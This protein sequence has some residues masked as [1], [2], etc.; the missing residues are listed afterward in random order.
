MQSYDTEFV[1]NT[2][3]NSTSAVCES[4]SW[5]ETFLSASPCGWPCVIFEKSHRRTRPPPPQR[6]VTARQG[7][8]IQPAAVGRR[9][10]F[11]GGPDGGWQKENFVR[12][13]TF[14]LGGAAREDQGE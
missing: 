8:R 11:I 1:Q 5:D 4:V 9:I 14:T 3:Q 12:V 2:S 10:K 7:R 6:C 13:E